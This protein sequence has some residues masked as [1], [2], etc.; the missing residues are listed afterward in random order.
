MNNEQKQDRKEIGNKMREE[1][2]GV[3]RQHGSVR[4]KWVSATV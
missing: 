4:D 1:S 2:R 3:L